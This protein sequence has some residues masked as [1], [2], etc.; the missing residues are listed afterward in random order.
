MSASVQLME[1][2]EEQHIAFETKEQQDR[3][4]IPV[5]DGSIGTLVAPMSMKWI[6]DDG[7]FRKFECPPNVAR[8]L[9]S[10]SRVSEA[11]LDLDRP[12][13]HSAR[14][15]SLV[16]Q[17]WIERKYASRSAQLMRSRSSPWGH[18]FRSPSLKSRPPE[19][20]RRRNVPAAINGVS[21][22][23]PRSFAQANHPAVI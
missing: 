4:F 1:I 3:R 7:L 8:K 19:T 13:R 10:Q 6:D 9:V 5:G 2:G 21:A 15:A 12:A 11:A 18:R 23:M 17:M 14:A 20:R 22:V 16:S